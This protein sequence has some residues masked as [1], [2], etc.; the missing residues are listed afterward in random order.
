MAS[1][2]LTALLRHKDFVRSLAR[3]LVSDP[4]QTDDIVQETY[5]AACRRPPR[6]EA[7]SCSWLKTT[8]RNVSGKWIRGEGRRRAR[9]RVVALPESV[10]PPEDLLE[11]IEL[12][13]K[14]V[15]AVTELREP[16]RTA[17]ILRFYEELSPSEIAERLGINEGAVRARLWRGIRELRARLDD[18]FDGDRDAWQRA[19]IA[20]SGLDVSSPG[21]AEAVTT[22]TTTHLG[23]ALMNGTILTI[24]GLFV[25]GGAAVVIRGVGDEQ[26]LGPDVAR[27]ILPSAPA[28]LDVERQRDSDAVRK[29]AEEAPI[30]TPASTAEEEVAAVDRGTG[31]LTMN[32]VDDVTGAPLSFVA[33]FLSADRFGELYSV[34]EARADLTATTFDVAIR[35]VGYESAAV[36][37]VQVTRDGTVA[38]GDIRLRRGTGVIEGSIGGADAD[39]ETVVELFGFVAG[40]EASGIFWAVAAVEGE[41]EWTD[42]A[43]GASAGDAGMTIEAGAEFVIERPGRAH[44]HW[45]QVV[46]ADGRFRFEGLPAGAYHLRA[47]DPATPIGDF[48]RVELKK[49]A[50]KERSLALAPS[51]ELTVSIVDENGR[52]VDVAH[53]V[54]AGGD[55]LTL[56]CLNVDGELIA[57]RNFTGAD[58]SFGFLEDVAFGSESAPEGSV[59]DRERRPDDELLPAFP[60]PTGHAAGLDGEH[61][62]HLYTLRG[63]PRTAMTLRAQVGDRVG[64]LE[65]DLT[66]GA[67]QDLRLTLSE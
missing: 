35:V 61:R 16:S 4:H 49:G 65:C 44:Q 33:R 9:E 38:L 51:A 46:G 12:E 17:I 20:T 62:E 15:Q 26:K 36:D 19:L 37:G 41:N 18:R 60:R 8:V 22:T 67:L 43:F 40:D 39:A 42:P 24:A 23:S 11:R 13:R 27:T 14:V 66:A 10:D 63:L 1:A 53:P 34:G 6:V 48:V 50:I 47:I 56:S 31:L 54:V 55:F 28:S 64:E 45:T 2:S 30:T 29:P 3:N 57:Y 32:V 58:E 7:A 59:I 25:V 5:L 52:P 21:G